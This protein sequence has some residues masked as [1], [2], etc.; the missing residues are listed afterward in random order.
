ME[1]SDFND[2]VAEFATDVGALLSSTL[3]GETKFETLEVNS[4]QFRANL[5]ISKALVISPSGSD[6]LHLRC[7]YRLCPN[8]DGSHLAV[9]KSS[10]KIEFKTVDKFVPIVRFEYDRGARNKPASHFQF[11]ADSVALG[12]LLSRAR[13][14]EAAA[15][16][17]RIHFPMGGERYRVCLE[18]VVELLVNEFAAKPI[19]GWKQKVEEG[20]RKYERI[21]T[22]TVLRNNLERCAAILREEGYS[23]EKS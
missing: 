4:R 6:R 20:R 13:R 9:E 19:P 3:V 1:L 5:D 18:D 16:Q 10:L 21:Q 12:L 7:A 8:T 23:V 15:Q 17:Q 2:Q 22:D 11:H 14:Y